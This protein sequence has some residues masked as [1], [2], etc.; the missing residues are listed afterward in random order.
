MNG[1]M[2]HSGSELCSREALALIKAPEAT[3]THKPIP[4]ISLV[5]AVLE[6][7][8]F[9]HINVIREEF[10]VSKDGMKLFGVLDLETQFDGCR[11]TLGLRNA[12]DKSMRLGLVV[13]FRV[14]VCDN[15]AFSGDFQ[16]VLAK[17]S[18]HFNLQDSLAVGIDQMQRNFKPMQ[19][20]VLTWKGQQISDE[21]AK[22]MIYEAFIQE[23][24]VD[25]PK[26]IARFV[27]KNYFDPP[28]SE[29]APRTHFSLHNAFTT[30]FKQL[31]PIPQYKA[32]AALGDF[33]PKQLGG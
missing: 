24:L 6:T 27:H 3:D 25:V 20:Q 13:G 15:M 26:H 2:A 1:L 33:F 18:K 8:A 4:H 16:P 22:L 14:F 30:A 21:Y 31:D 12:N 10:A 7:L 32:T 17:H 5:Q 23:Q 11:F 28:F 9:R 19:E 29:F